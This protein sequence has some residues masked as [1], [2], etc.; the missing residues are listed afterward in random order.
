MRLRRDIVSCK[1]KKEVRDYDQKTY[2]RFGAYVVNP[3]L[4]KPVYR[5]GDSGEKTKAAEAATEA[6]EVAGS[7]D[8]AAEPSADA[9]EDRLEAVLQQRDVF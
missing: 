7:S 5:L 3:F 9:C 4:S 1:Y 6:A 8:E 2:A